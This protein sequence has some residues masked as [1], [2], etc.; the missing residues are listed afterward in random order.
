[1]NFIF[2][3][4]LLWCWWLWSGEVLRGDRIVN[5]PYQVQMN[6]DK[7]CELVCAKP[8]QPAKLSVA[9]SKLIA[10]RIQEEYYVH[11]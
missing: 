5:T 11:L 8:G 10:E 2:L 9:E 3:L 6:Q 7:K 1:M 4:L